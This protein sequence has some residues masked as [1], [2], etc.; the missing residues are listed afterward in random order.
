MKKILVATV[1]AL[2]IA[3]CKTAAIHNVEE[4]PIT[5]YDGQELSLDQ[6]ERAIAVAGS[7]LGWVM[8]P[9]EPGHMVGILDIRKHKAVIDVFY[10]SDSFS[11]QYKDSTNLLYDPSGKI[12]RNYN[13]WIGN[14]ERGINAEIQRLR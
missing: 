4:A 14:L 11:I 2:A 1:L 13:N 10:D 7:E 5:R 3:G 8:Q 6:V 12:H 9:V